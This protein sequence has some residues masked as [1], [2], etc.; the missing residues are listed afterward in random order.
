[1]DAYSGTVSR[2]AAN[3][4]ALRYG[5]SPAILWAQLAVESDRRWDAFRFEQDFYRRY[6]IGNG[7]AKAAKYGPLAACSFGPLQILL[8]TA[9]EHG[10]AGEPHELFGPPGLTAGASLLA[11]LLRWAGGDYARALAAYN[12]GRGGNAKPPFR[13]QAYVDRVMARVERPA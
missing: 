1:M 12:G 6:I 9:M 11:D 5:L 3:A 8:E 13:N 2:S 10:Y 4:A 7:A